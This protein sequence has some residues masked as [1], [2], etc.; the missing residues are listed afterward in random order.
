[1]LE[2]FIIIKGVMKK[3]V[4]PVFQIKKILENIS[5]VFYY[6]NIIPE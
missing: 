3:M 4:Q 6:D 5:L 2:E 1:M